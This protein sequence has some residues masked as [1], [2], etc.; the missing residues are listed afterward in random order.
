MKSPEIWKKRIKRNVNSHDVNFPMNLNLSIS[1]LA[2]KALKIVQHIYSNNKSTTGSNS[3]IKKIM[4]FPVF[5][6]KN[7]SYLNFFRF[8]FSL[9]VCQFKCTLFMQHFH[10]KFYFEKIYVFQSFLCS[11][12]FFLCCSE[13]I[14]NPLKNCNI[15][16]IK[17][18]EG[19]YT[20]HNLTN[21]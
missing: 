10:I 7:F 19:Y 14:S 11:P 17:K 18:R 1:F 2:W 13:K 21:T 20:F 4:I 3:A 12:H 15:K 8:F 16:I 5:P 6:I 9:L